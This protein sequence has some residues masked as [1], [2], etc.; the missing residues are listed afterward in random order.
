MT[1]T[2][3]NAAAI[4]A[5]GTLG[6]CFRRGLPA[7]VQDAAM[8]AGGLGVCMISLAGILEQML[9]AGPDGT[10]TS[11]GGMLL[12]L[13]LV[14]GGVVGEALRL[15]DRIAGLGRSVECRLG[16]EGFAKGFVGA[17]LLFCVGAMAILGAIEDGLYG[18][19]G[20]LFTKAVLDGIFSIVMAASLGY[21]VSFSAIP[22]LLY[23]GAITLAASL[24]GPLLEGTA[25]LGQICMVG[26]AVVLLLGTNM[27]GITQVKPANFLP[28][29]LCPV[30]YNLIMML[31]NSW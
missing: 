22:V 2:L 18:K 26:Y 1:G 6:L 9:R 27:L 15:E 4:V 17:S 14:I 5:G 7:A 31:K 21:G 29:V 20:I 16:R 24:L 13:S 11:A 10:I 19:T 23:Q 3:V 25:L 12:V 30:G 8:Q 28:A